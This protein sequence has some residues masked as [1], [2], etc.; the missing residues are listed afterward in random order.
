MEQKGECGGEESAQL[1]HWRHS[2]HH[3]LLLHTSCFAHF[4]SSFFYPWSERRKNSGGG[5][6]E[7]GICK[8]PLALGLQSDAHILGGRPIEHNGTYC[9]VDMNS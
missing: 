5:W 2:S 8:Q 3:S 7:R 6:S 4:L 9:L 1:E